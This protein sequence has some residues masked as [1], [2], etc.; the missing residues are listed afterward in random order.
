MTP[1]ERRGEE[2]RQPGKLK[3]IC[4]LHNPTDKVS[5]ISTKHPREATTD[6]TPSPEAGILGFVK[7]VKSFQRKYFKHEI[8]DR[9]PSMENQ[10]N[11][12]VDPVI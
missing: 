10:V 4:G 7:N 6:L 8:L 11:F 12:V 3:H 1:W 2:Q 9:S 5:Y